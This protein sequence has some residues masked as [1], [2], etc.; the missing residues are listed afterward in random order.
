MA[1][2][3][4]INAKSNDNLDVQ[5]AVFTKYA[6]NEDKKGFPAKLTMGTDP[7]R[8][9]TVYY[10]ELADGS[11]LANVSGPVP[12]KDEA[13]RPIIKLV[14]GKERYEWETYINKT[15]GKEQ[16]VDAP[17]ATFGVKIGEKSGKP[18]I[19]SKVFFE[20]TLLPMARLKYLIANDPDGKAQA[21]TDLNTIQSKHG[22]SLLLNFFPSSAIAAKKMSEVFKHEFDYNE[23]PS[24]RTQATPSAPSPSL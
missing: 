18:Y 3:Y 7:G 19:F 20:E 6:G 22:N 9:C 1:I 21:I 17:L 14:E 15:T 13:G 23:P 10:N 2:I 11:V 4:A 12:K 8:M 24:R 16:W 5:F